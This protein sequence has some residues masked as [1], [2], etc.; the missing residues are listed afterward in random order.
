MQQSDYW[1][2][3]QQAFN[4]DPISAPN[5]DLPSARTGGL[6]REHPHLKAI[7][8]EDALA[9]GLQR[10]HTN[11]PKTEISASFPEPNP[12]ITSYRSIGSLPEK[13]GNREKRGTTR[14][15]ALYTGPTGTLDYR[16]TTRIL[17]ES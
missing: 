3:C 2:V 5:R 11:Q 8:V 15:L 12:V 7:N 16:S 9:T 10:P 13:L 1:A 4:G 14:R 17:S 6:R